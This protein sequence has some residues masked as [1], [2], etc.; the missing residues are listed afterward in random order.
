[1]G[2]PA[3]YCCA[4]IGATVLALALLIQGPKLIDATRGPSAPDCIDADGRL[5]GADR[6]CVY[7]PDRDSCPSEGEPKANDWP[8][9]QIYLHR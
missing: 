1:M 3:I 5:S 9:L 8:C 2:R 4:I 7:H 6:A